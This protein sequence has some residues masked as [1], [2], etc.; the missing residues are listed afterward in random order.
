M[1]Y[2]DYIN[3]NT[4]INRVVK[5]IDIASNYN[6]IYLGNVSSNFGKMI[7]A[8]Y[9]LKNQQTVI[10]ITSD[11]YHAT[12]AYDVFLDLLGKENVSFFP[13]EEFVSSKMIASSNIFR[14]A[15]MNT[16]V[17]II[18]KVPQVIITN[19]EGAL[20]NIMSTKRLE[21]SIIH[22]KKGKIIEKSYLINELVIRGYKKQV[23]TESQGMFSVRGEVVDI[24]PVNEDEPI[25]INFFDDEIE[26]IKYFN[27][28]TQMSIRKID[29]SIIY[30]LYEM[31]YEDVN[32]IKQ[33]VN[34]TQDV[35]DKIK[36]DIFNL[37]NYEN[38]DQLYIYL[39]YIDNN[40]QNVLSSIEEKTIFIEEYNDVIS[41]ELLE[42]TEVSDFLKDNHFHMPK[43]F[44]KV[45]M[46]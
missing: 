18:N 8:N 43:N 1:N 38:L 40:Y 2:I 37:E 10:Y 32:E 11:I 17:Q 15:R 33:A 23:V 34:S 42:K 12:K 44:F 20:K 14:L 22:L 41:K 45:S 31:F 25:R 7:V 16:L 46:K 29:E 4:K 27:V 39:P 21:K 13:G 6:N 36:E 19:T 26:T 24:F 35:N 28:E 5:E 30:P 3:K 9:F